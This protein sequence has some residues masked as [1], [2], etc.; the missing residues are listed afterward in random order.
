MRGAAGTCPTTIRAVGWVHEKTLPPVVYFAAQMV[1]ARWQERS[2]NCTVCLRH[3]GVG[4]LFGSLLCLHLGAICLT[5]CPGARGVGR[6][7]F[8]RLLRPNGGGRLIARSPP[9]VAILHE[10]GLLRKRLA[11]CWALRDAK[12]AAARRGRGRPERSR[13]DHQTAGSMGFRGN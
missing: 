13:V 4:R 2:E 3:P 6:R 5:R 9:I 10:W 1:A 7:L 11:T 8:G 12:G